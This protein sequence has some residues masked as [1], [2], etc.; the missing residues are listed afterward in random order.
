MTRLRRTAADKEYEGGVRMYHRRQKKYFLLFLLLLYPI[1]TEVAYLSTPSAD[2]MSKY[3]A[4]A[5]CGCGRPDFVTDTYA[6]AMTAAYD[7]EG[8]VSCTACELFSVRK[9][10]STECTIHTGGTMHTTGADGA[11]PSRFLGYKFETDEQIFY[12]RGASLD[13]LVVVNK[14]NDTSITEP[15][16]RPGD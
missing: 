15:I 14:D 4:S 12:L 10:G 8:I 1:T 11:T 2:E 13:T 16:K 3:M 5:W 7:E 9:V 6:I